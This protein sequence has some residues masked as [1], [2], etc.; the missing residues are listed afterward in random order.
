M[1]LLKMIVLA[2]VQGITEFL[3][4]SSDG[5]LTVLEHFMGFGDDSLLIT[6]VLHGGTLLSILCY[7]RQGLWG[8][9]VERN[10]RLPLYVFLGTL[11]VVILVFGLKLGFGIDMEKTLTS[12]WWAVGGWLVTAVFLLAVHR[13]TPPATGTRTLDQLTWRDALWIGSAQAIAPLPGIS[14]SGSTI[15][16][17][18]RLGLAPEAAARFSFYLGIPAI[19]GAVFLAL[20]K[21]V[22]LAARHETMPNFSLW[23]LLIGFIVSFAVG[24]V[25][26]SLLI[27]MLQR[28]KFAWFGY[29]CLAAAAA[30]AVALLVHG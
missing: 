19:G 7:Y 8:L 24:F 27:R 2:V 15:C 20:A 16:T 4:I 28:G 9:F 14:R 22:K 26:L 12:P 23:H 3:P 29:Y 17:A 21:L 18:T 11:P 25:A 13:R 10:W 5:H 30:T 1:E 6:L